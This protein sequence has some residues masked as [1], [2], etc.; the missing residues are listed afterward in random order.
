MDW[1]QT[2]RVVL[3]IV[4]AVLCLGL[5]VGGIIMFVKF[6]EQIIY[7]LLFLLGASICLFLSLFNLP[8]KE[9][10]NRGR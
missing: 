10:T 1:S 6:P 8:I 7:G 2:K 3:M 9:K 4:F 5:I